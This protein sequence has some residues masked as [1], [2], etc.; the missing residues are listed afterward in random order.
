MSAYTSIGLSDHA[1][2]K[3]AMGRKRPI[4]YNNSPCGSSLLTF[5]GNDSSNQHKQI[6]SSM[7]Y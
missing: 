6:I 2:I 7:Y 5:I 4:L 3:K 1:K